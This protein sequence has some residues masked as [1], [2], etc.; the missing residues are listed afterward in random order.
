MKNVEIVFKNRK[1]KF[2]DEVE[3]TQSTKKQ[4]INP[5]D[6]MPT[7]FFASNVWQDIDDGH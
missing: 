4:K 6:G 5:L 1:V 3:K 7:Y 2:S